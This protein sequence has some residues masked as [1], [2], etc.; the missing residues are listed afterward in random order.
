MPTSSTLS[1]RTFLAT[2]AAIGAAPPL[3]L[4]RAHAAT[5]DEV[6]PPQP[7]RRLTATAADGVRIA[8]QEWGDPKG[9][10]LL[11]IHGGM[12]SHLCW[13]RQTT[14]LSQCRVVT[15]DLRGHGESD[16]PTDPAA[17]AQPRQW[18]DDVALAMKTA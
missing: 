8:I 5:T 4:E 9:P 14:A 13:Q 16:K 12:Q 11:L 17:Y 15:L 2:T 1:R 3:A 10:E 18:A 7:R 6:P